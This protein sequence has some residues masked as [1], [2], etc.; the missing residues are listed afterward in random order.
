MNVQ[1]SLL[2]LAI[3]SRPSIAASKLRTSKVM[4]R[5]CELLYANVKFSLASNGFKAT[6]P[7]T[8]LTAGRTALM[9]TT[10]FTSYSLTPSSCGLTVVVTSIAAYSSIADALVSRFYRQNIIFKFKD[11]LTSF[12]RLSIK[13]IILILIQQSEHS[14]I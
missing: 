11:T 5:A 3:T 2:S 6:V 12:N 7:N 13:C 9:K 10:F 14:G 4:I 1:Y 8:G